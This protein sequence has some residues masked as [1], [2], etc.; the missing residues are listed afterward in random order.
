MVAALKRLALG[1]CAAA[2]SAFTADFSSGMAPFAESSATR[3]ASQ[4]VA[5]EEG[6]LVLKNANQMYG[7]AAPVE[8]PFVA[9]DSLVVQ[10]EVTLTD[11]LTCGGAYVK[12]LEAPVDVK[13]FDNE[14][15]YVLMFGPDKCGATDKVHFI[16]R[17][18]N[19][20]SGETYEH[21]LKDPPRVKGDKKPHLYRAVIKADN[22]Y[23]VYIDDKEEAAG[24]LLEGLEPP[25]E[26]PKKIDDKDDAKPDDWVDA[27][28]IDDP[29]A[30]KPFD[31][32][33]DAPKKIEDDEAEIPKGWLESEPVLVPDPEATIPDDWDVEEDG[34]WE[35]P[36]V[37]NPKCESA[38]GC[39]PWSPPLID[40][41]KFKG[42][43]FAP[44][45]DNPAYKGVWKPRK[46][47]NPEYFVPENPA[48]SLKPIGAVAVEIWTTNAGI[49]YDSFYVGGSLD[50]AK[51]AAESYYEKKA[52]EQAAAEVKKAEKAA[53]KAAKQTGLRGVLK[54]VEGYAIQALE[55]G[56]AQP[57]AAAGTLLAVL[58][59][60]LMLCKKKAPASEDEDEDDDD[61]EED[62][63]EEEDEPEPPK[64]RTRTPKAD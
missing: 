42:K 6:A 23:A 33:E 30:S 13:K 18:K 64:R 54:K 11:G 15:P 17:Q 21:H 9:D 46:I 32:D 41:P 37:P 51:A 63:E 52:A 28:K 35:A 8:P 34:A 25:L 47:D 60:L 10:Y 58:V 56:K 55:Q 31:W 20:K 3:Y 39:G 43:W 49:T 19:P 38:P 62:E 45:I 16:L 50:D 40:N 12:L 2:A 14:S 61:E 29:D 57:L 7:I 22:T 4:A 27:A 5:V 26:P 59:T 1:G 36:E 24:P 44:K 48:K 53:R